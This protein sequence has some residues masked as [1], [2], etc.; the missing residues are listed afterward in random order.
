MVS[1]K[2]MLASVFFRWDGHADGLWGD[3]F[4][5]REILIYLS[6]PVKVTFKDK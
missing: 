5:K 2:I 6:R 4:I 3:T 1:I